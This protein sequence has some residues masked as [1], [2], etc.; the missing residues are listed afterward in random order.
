MT[1]NIAASKTKSN[2]MQQSRVAAIC[3]VIAVAFSL[4]EIWANSFSYLPTLK[5]NAIHLSFL[6]LL[7]FLMYPMKCG[8]TLFRIID[9]IFAIVSVGCTLYFC[10]SFNALYTRGMVPIPRD[11]IIAGVGLVLTLEACRRAAGLILPIL[12]IMFLLYA[13]YGQYFPGILAH[14]GFSWSNIMFKMFMID[15]GVFGTTLTIS[16]TYLFL[17]V[18]FSELLAKT[19]VGEFFN[20]FALALLGHRRGGPAQVAVVSSA[21]MGT[22]SGSS[23]A[24]VATSGS[25][26]IPLMKSIGYSPDF[27]AGVE[28]LASTGGMIMPPVM[29]AA[30]FLMVGFLGVPYATIMYAAIIPAILYYIS[31]WFVIEM[32]AQRLGL[33]GLPKNDLPRLRQVLKQEGYLIVP[34]VVVV[35]GIVTGITVIKAA[36]EGMISSVLISIVGRES[37]MNLGRKIIDALDSGAR[38]MVPIGL[39]C[40]VAGIIVGVTGMTALG[41]TLAYNI[42]ELSGGSVLLALVLILFTSLVASMGLPAT[43]CYVVVATVTAPALIRMNI[44]P[45]AAH[46]FV[47]WY[48]C[49]SGITPPVALAS[50][51]AAGIAGSIPNKTAITAF[52][53]AVPGF[54][55]PFLMVYRPELLGIG[56]TLPKL[57]TSTGI[58]VV[59]CLSTACCTHGY[60]VGKLSLWERVLMGIS[61]LMLIKPDVWSYFGVFIILGVLLYHWYHSSASTN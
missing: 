42:I 29:G 54:L 35:Y 12:S 11:Y 43:A 44:P 28:A 23:I 47:F 3:S 8:A 51:T 7:C 9:L 58:A 1:T 16:A 57:L 13:R 49:L 46:F 33:K 22:L 6:L 30:A 41:S 45:L 40:A 53:M 50:Y 14:G 24:N 5:I 10:F 55:L 2:L 52:R 48:G 34:V 19:G 27:A 15:T 56:V 21:L 26:T 60:F 20:N 31:L 32:E 4:F 18:L 38:R 36:F 17:F 39:A 25:F 61:S 59:T 37:R